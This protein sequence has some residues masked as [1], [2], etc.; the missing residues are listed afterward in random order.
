MVSM[1][2]NEETPTPESPVQ[3]FFSIVLLLAMPRSVIGINIQRTLAR[4]RVGE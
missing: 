4:L 2:G 3:R 1:C